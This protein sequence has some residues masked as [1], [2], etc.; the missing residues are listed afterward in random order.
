MIGNTEYKGVRVDNASHLGEPATAFEQRAALGER[1]YGLLQSWDRGRRKTAG[2]GWLGK[3]Q[4]A[5]CKTIPE[6][7]ERELGAACR[8]AK[9]QHQD[10]SRGR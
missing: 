7:E 4:S 6:I 8:Q 5:L 3:Y 10:R 1:V 9:E 2:E